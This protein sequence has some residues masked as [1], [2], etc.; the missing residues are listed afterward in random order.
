MTFACFI[1]PNE[2]SWEKKNIFNVTIYKMKQC[3]DS[4]L[5]MFTFLLVNFEK[6]KKMLRKIMLQIHPNHVFKFE[7][8]N[9]K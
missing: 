1:L 6:H 3:Q 4:E 9:I 8:L 2:T 5:L 7:T